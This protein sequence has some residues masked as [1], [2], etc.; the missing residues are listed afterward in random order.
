MIRTI[1]EVALVIWLVLAL[2][3]IIA[4]T[5]RSEAMNRPLLR[6]ERKLNILNIALMMTWI[7]LLALSR[8]FATG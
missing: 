4:R 7:M 8:L 3:V 1:G 2:Y 5:T 6:Y